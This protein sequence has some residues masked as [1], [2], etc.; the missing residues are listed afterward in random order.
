M[1]AGGNS[2]PSRRRAIVTRV[3]VSGC[4]AT[5]L[6]VLLMSAPR[7]ALSVF[8]GSNPAAALAALALDAIDVTAV[9]T[10]VAA[11]SVV[12]LLRKLP[13][14]IGAVIA[15]TI[16]AVVT[17]ELVREAAGSTVPSVDLP[18]GQLI[19]VAALLGAASM[20]AS[21]AWR[22]A[23]LGLG[24]VVTLTVAASALIIGSSSITGIAGA[25]LVAF[26]WWSACSIVMLY[27]P[28]AA[29]REARN[30]LDTAALAVQRKMGHSR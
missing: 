23:I 20:V 22:P 7:V 28:D 13:Y 17:G 9:L 11:L 29:D 8:A 19:A 3:A 4:S 1:A 16:G 6:L 5:L 30:P 25:L 24:T 14:G 15:C 27:S 10:V 12:A 21:T 2:T 18:Y 26:A